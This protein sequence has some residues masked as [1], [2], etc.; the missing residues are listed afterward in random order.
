MKFTLAYLAFINVAS[1]LIFSYDK[2]AA[3]NNRRRISEHSLHLFEILGGA[4]ANLLL[5]YI[6][7]HKNQKTKYYIWTWLIL[8]AWILIGWLLI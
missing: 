5:M 1:G 4:F 6:I 2:L 7:H 3:K 8:A